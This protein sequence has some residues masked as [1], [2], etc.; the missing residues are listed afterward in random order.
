MIAT[1]LVTLLAGSPTPAEMVPNPGYY[2]GEYILIG[3]KADGSLIEDRAR[4]SIASPDLL[5]LETCAMGDGTLGPTT[6]THEGASPLEGP[7]AG[8]TIFCRFTND[9]D[10]YPRL[11]CAS[12]QTEGV[13]M[14]L[15]FWPDFGEFD[16]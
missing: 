16:C 13:P 8:A 10:N 4:M 5:R 11:T 3:R 6:S 12:G 7:F 9:G 14:L 15:T 1:V 2:A